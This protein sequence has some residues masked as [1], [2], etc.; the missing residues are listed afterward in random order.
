MICVWHF[1]KCMSANLSDSTE[2]LNSGFGIFMGPEEQNVNTSDR[3][4]YKASLRDRKGDLNKWRDIAY[5]QTG[6]LSIVSVPQDTNK[7]M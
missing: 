4:T 7:P 6:R 5:L 1:A 3:K 2:R